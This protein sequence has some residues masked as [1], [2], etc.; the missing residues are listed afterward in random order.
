ML[1]SAAWETETSTGRAKE[2]LHIMAQRELVW[3]EEEEEEGQVKA[4][5]L[6]VA[7]PAE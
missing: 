2:H 7:G 4:G 1:H 6:Q 3:Q 5:L